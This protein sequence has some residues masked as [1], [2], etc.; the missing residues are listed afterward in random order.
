M[1]TTGGGTGASLSIRYVA[2]VTGQ[3]RNGSTNQSWAGQGPGSTA[4]DAASVTQIGSAVPTGTVTYSLHSSS[5]CTGSPISTQT[6]TL[7]GGTAPSSSVTAP[8]NAGGYTYKASYSGDSSYASA[9]SC[10]YFVVSQAQPS[11]SVTAPSPVAVGTPTSVTATLTG[12]YP[13]P[14]STRTV[15]Y[16]AYK[17]SE[18]CD[19]AP[20]G[21]ADV[22]VVNGVATWSS[23]TPPAA[24]SY[25]VTASYSGDVN[26]ATL[27]EACNGA[28]SATVVATV[29]VDK[30]APFIVLTSP[31]YGQSFNGP[32][33]VAGVAGT[34]PGDGQFASVEVYQGSSVSGSPFSSFALSRHPTTGSYGGE[35]TLPEG[36]FTL[37]A[38]QVDDAANTGY[39][40][41]VVVRM[42]TTLPEVSDDVPT[43]WQNGPRAVHLTATD[44]GS[45]VQ[46]IY[47]E[48]GTNP[49]T[50]TTGSPTYDPANPPTLQDGES[51]KYF[52][53]DKA[54]N[55]SSVKTSAALKVDTV[56]PSTSDNVPTAWSTAPVTVTLTATDAS[57]G[58]VLTYYTTDGSMPGPGSPTYAVADKPTLTH[59]QAIRY[60]SVDVA[61]NAEAVKT[62]AAAR[63]D[64]TA[65][66]ITITEPAGNA[67]Y[68][69][70]TVFSGYAGLAPGDQPVV[71]E[72]RFYAGST[73]DDSAYLFRLTNIAID[74]TTGY[75]YTGP[76][77]FGSSVFSVKVLQYDD[78]GNFGTASATFKQDGTKPEV[79]DDVPTTW[80]NGPRAVHLT[81]TDPHSG[82]KAVYYETG[83][84]PSPPTPARRPT[85]RRTRR[86]SRPAS[87]SDTSPRTTWAGRRTPRRRRR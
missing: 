54:T 30:T 85:T 4:Y 52:V 74:Q 47:Y 55:V 8:L 42:D 20:V 43:R 75:W 50:P 28:R 63:V 48:K 26:N 81:A 59:G 27:S 17:S 19:G 76:I 7:S 9:S 79:T 22:N 11:M 5:T 13:T 69:N 71:R 65:P 82:V 53:R 60:Y 44:V 73:T 51:I 57:S 61:G 32:V 35:V 16:Y 24:G 83:T 10:D 70:T 87:R 37:R 39:S 14:S 68:S 33:P 72:I 31:R 40:T 34:A 2:S 45:G 46:A 1:F 62:S 12:E 21:S 78:A 36:T 58:V 3:V 86:R 67:W 6:V 15:T 49:S 66:A 23:F 64:Q 25:V 77:S 84:S 80:Q 29:A 18:V 56:A 38:G 41:A